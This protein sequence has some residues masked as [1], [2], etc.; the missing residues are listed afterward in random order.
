MSRRSAGFFVTSSGRAFST[1]SWASASVIC[2]FLACGQAP[3]S[4]DALPA[5][6]WNL[7]YQGTAGSVQT[8]RDRVHETVEER[9]SLGLL[10]RE[11]GIIVDVVRDSPAWKAGLGPDMKLLAVNERPWSPRAFRDAI[12]TDATS[13]APVSLSVQNG[14]QTFLATIHDHRGSCYPRLERNGNPDIMTQILKPQSRGSG[15][16]WNRIVSLI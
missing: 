15:W 2:L 4:A 16:K 12:A 6:G 5:S 13:T 7:T 10:L 11:D 3:A 9:F 8:A 14:S 1:N